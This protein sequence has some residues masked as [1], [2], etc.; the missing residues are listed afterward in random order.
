MKADNAIIMA[1]GTSSRFAPLSYEQHKA[2]TVVNGEILIERQIRQL[3]EAGIPKI[4]IVT[5]YK[6][7]QFSYLIP[8]FGVELIHNPNYLTRNNNGSIWAARKV[9]RNSFI[10]S[11]DNYFSENPFENEVDYS[12]YAAEYADGPTAGWC[13]EEDNEGYISSVTIGGNNSWYMLGHTFWSAEFS[14]RFLK[15]LEAEY[16]LPGT[17][18][19]LW[20][21]IFMAHLDTLK[22]KIRKYD[23][24]VI[25]E[26]DTMDE[27]REFDTSY[28]TDTR[29]N[30]LKKLA[31]ELNIKEKDIFH[32]QTLKGADT[33]AIGFQF[34]CPKGNYRYMYRT[35]K[36]EKNADISSLTA[37]LGKTVSFTC[38]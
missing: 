23:P 6:S 32:I 9:L 31:S 30:I 24:D 27:L 13:M 14:T 21:K 5:G 3:K 11:S 28:I 38:G 25:H 12:Y 17:A 10:C 36:M 35:G 19:K 37:S 7:E 8:K 33:E 15:I 22:M 16:D 20:E 34:E 1:A 29:S 4:Y 18:N 2:M 26:F